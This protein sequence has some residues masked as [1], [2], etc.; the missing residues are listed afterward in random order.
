[1][2]V[3][4]VSHAAS[5]KEICLQNSD[6]FVWVEKNQDCVPISPCAQPESSNYYK[7]YC[8][9]KLLD[10]TMYFDE[11]GYEAKAA[12]FISNE[13]AVEEMG[14]YLKHVLNIPGGCK[15]V[16]PYTYIQRDPGYSYV[17]C[18]TGDGG[19]VEFKLPS[20]E[21]SDWA[22]GKLYYGQQF[23]CVALGGKIKDLSDSSI[24]FDCEGINEKQC[25]IIA[26]GVAPKSS[27][28]PFRWYSWQ[29][30]EIG[31]SCNMSDE[32]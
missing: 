18:M 27:L 29:H 9:D 16:A 7:L 13:H 1:M 26:E 5:M 28:Y 30:R 19:F 8:N 25:N 22:A 14:W 20:F 17:A 31:F 23:R 21:D 32:H 24:D 12:K 15:E 2:S 11:V 10:L 3:I 4:G 6:K